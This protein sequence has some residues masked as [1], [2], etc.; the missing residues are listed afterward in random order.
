M[1]T[2]ANSDTPISALAAEYNFLKG[3]SIEKRT[4]Q[5]VLKN[6]TRIP[7]L[8]LEQAAMLC[9]VSVSTFSRF[10]KDMGY[11]SYTAFRMKIKDALASYEFKPQIYRGTQACTCENFIDIFSESL[12]TDLANFRA[13]FRPEDYASLA[14]RLHQSTH[15]YFHDTVY[16]TIRL[17]LQADLAVTGKMVTFSPNIPEQRRDVITAQ[18]GDL[19]ILNYD[20]HV[21]SKE[22]FNTIKQLR[23]KNAGIIIALMTSTRQISAADDCDYVFEVGR[24]ATALSDIMLRDLACQYLSMVYREKYISGK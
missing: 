9:D 4:A 8:T 1:G 19:F 18:P 6:I 3:H 16:S 2:N 10:C 24:G 7:E 17:S 11:E 13:H 23:A 21:R 12:Q 22:I 5:L 14:D 20:D 15:I